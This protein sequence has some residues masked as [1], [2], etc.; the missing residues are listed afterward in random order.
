M[1]LVFLSC[2]TVSCMWILA[3]KPE[4]SVKDAEFPFPFVIF[5]AFLSSGAYR[6]GG[7]IFFFGRFIPPGEVLAGITMLLLNVLTLAVGITTVSSRSIGDIIPTLHL[8]SLSPSISKSNLPLSRL[9]CIFAPHQ[10]SQ[11]TA[12]PSTIP[13]HAWSHITT[14]LTTYTPLT[15]PRSRVQT[16][17]LSDLTSD[18]S[19]EGVVLGLVY[20]VSEPTVREKELRD[21]KEAEVEREKE[22][23]DFSC[24]KEAA[25]MVEEKRMMEGVL[26]VTGRGRVGF[27]V[28]RVD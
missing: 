21:L 12:S 11:N 9:Q 16:L 5:S 25:R 26:E 17:R 22:E 6:G 4:V 14:L 24:L 13:S 3:S 15:S 8:P 23:K 18:S 28:Y 19:L 2:E 1:P 10:P 20:T 27:L 7:F